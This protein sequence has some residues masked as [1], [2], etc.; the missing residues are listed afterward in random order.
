MDVI[1]G[2]FSFL[3]GTILASFS[4]VVI[5]RV[6]KH[7][8]IVKPNSFCGNCNKPIKWYDN[9]PIISF[10]ILKGKCRYCHEKIGWF[11]F[12][13]ELLGGISFLLIYLKFKISID[14]LFL[15]LITWLFLIIA[16][17]DYYNHF[18]YDTTQIIFLILSLGYVVYFSIIANKFPTEYLI[19][20]AVGFSFFF[21]IRVIGA[22]FLKRECLGMGDVIL[23]GT[24]GL[25]L[26][27]KALLLAVLLGSLIGSIISLLLIGLKIKNKEEEIA[28]G[29]YLIIGIY[30]AMVYG[31]DI[32]NWYLGLVI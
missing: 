4:G 15:F 23:M 22:F 1:L 14:T 18:I 17:I 10:L 32:I 9:I 29:P 25:L 5:Y 7:I 13:L 19:G 2:I 11:S 21:L 30:I 16:G 24:A 20:A 8:S 27:Y 12:I 6:P 28:F 3:L 31:K 26:G